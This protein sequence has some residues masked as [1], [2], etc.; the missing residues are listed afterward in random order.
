MDLWDIF[1]FAPE[2]G[3]I[4]LA[5]VSFIGSLI[6]FVPVPSF[7][8]LATMS[9]GEQFDLHILA[10]ISAFTATI[11]KQIIFYASYGGR[12]MISEKTKK[13]M[14]PFQ[15]L[16][17][18][19]GGAAAF[20]AAATPI[21]DDMVYIPLGLAKY[22]PKRFFIATLSG[23]IILCY[24]IVLIS[25]YTGL[26]I[27]E[28][29]LEDIDDPFAIYAGII[30]FGAIMTA[31]VILLLRLDWARILGRVA[32]WTLDDDEDATQN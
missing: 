1:P 30:V 2:V 10:L 8:L 4:G 22:N 12:R 32:P 23:K 9:V 3:Y 14:R 19:Y 21:P 5:L 29:I 18:R 20:V 15:K 16:V 27:L 11:A 28:P 31:I 6:P 24:I 13:R 26:S 7:I 25:H 17:K